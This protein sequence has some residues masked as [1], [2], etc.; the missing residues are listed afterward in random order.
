[1]TAAFEIGGYP[2]RGDRQSFAVA[3]TWKGLE[4]MAPLDTG[5]R[6]PALDFTL[7]DTEGNEISIQQALETGPVLLGIYKSSCAASKVMMPMLQR[8]HALHLENGLT[9]YGVSQDSANIT[10]SFARRY[11]LSIPLLLDGPEYP[12]SNAFDIRATPTVV[13]VSRGGT[14]VYSTMGF[15]RDQVEEIEAAVAI[16]LGVDRVQIITP[17]LA[18]IPFFVPG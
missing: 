17:D 7:Q 12:V 5:T 1:M 2:C 13:L 10:R 4:A 14:V 16:E 8:I 15:M 9:T 3:C 18:E 6:A 11:G